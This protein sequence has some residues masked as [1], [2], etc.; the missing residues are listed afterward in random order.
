MAW[1]DPRT[2]VADETVT[3]A[4]LNEQIRDNETYLKDTLD[5]A[6]QKDGSIAFTG[7]QPLGANKLTG[8]ADPTANQDA[9]TKAY[10]DNSP[11]LH[12]AGI[13][14]DGTK[15]QFDDSIQSSNRFWI[16]TGKKLSGDDATGQIYLR[17][18]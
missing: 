16:P 18:V 3:A 8:V 7:D 14:W 10:V 4:Q 12:L 11:I 9:A 2:W 17:D 5:D 6:V 1:T 15:F 13:Y